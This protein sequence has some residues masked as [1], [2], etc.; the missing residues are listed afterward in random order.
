MKKILALSELEYNFDLQNDIRAEFPS[1]FIYLSGKII[2]ALKLNNDTRP[3]TLD[4]WFELCHPENHNVIQKIEYAISNSNTH[5]NF[6][7]ITRKL[8]CGDGVYRPFRLEAFLKRNSNGAV[9]ELLGKETPL[10]TAWLEN[11][12]NEGDLIRLDNN[13]IYEAVNVQGIMTLRDLDLIQDAEQENLRLRREIQRRI[14]NA[15]ALF[16]DDTAS[17]NNNHDEIKERL[18]KII[19]SALNSL[20]S[21]NKLRALKKILPEKNI[22]VGVIGLAGSGKSSFIN[23]LL[24][25]KLL[26]ESNSSKINVPV[27]CSNGDTRHAVIYYQNGMTAKISGDKLNS[28]KNL[29][30]NEFN[31]GN[32]HGIERIEF[33]I[34]GA[35]IPDGVKFVDTPSLNSAGEN[36]VM[37]NLIPELDFIIYITPSRAALRKY[38]REFINTLGERII[39]ILSEIDTE[40]DDTEAG[41]IITTSQN[42]IANAIA[43]IKNIYDKPVI[44]VSAKTALEKFYDR[45]SNEWLNANFDSVIK[46]FAQFKDNAFKNALYLRA[47]RLMDT[48]SIAVKNRMSA[49]I[50]WRVRENLDAVKN[51][52]AEFENDIPNISEYDSV[53]VENLD[54]GDDNN[55]N[56]IASLFTSMREREFK[57]KF[58]ELSAF[59]F[60]KRIILLAPDQSDSLKLFS[61]LAHDI[62]LTQ[63]FSNDGF[64]YSGDDEIL[65]R[66]FSAKRI[67][68][69]HDDILIAPSDEFL[70]DKNL[71]YN[72]IFSERVP[73]ISLD[74]ARIDTGFF[75]LENAKYFDALKNFQW[76]LAFGS[77]AFFDIKPDDLNQHVPERLNDFL[78]KHLLKMP[79][80]FI[81]E[82]YQIKHAAF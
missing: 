81:Y 75:E 48:L 45:K 78:K 22:I 13:K 56:L 1:R 7:T 10:L 8:Y 49:S 79:E 23:A 33:V 26:P 44:P 66:D 24:G 9:I 53:F 41:R 5:E 61:R 12:A 21:N 15:N 3:K 69:L 14:F 59:K 60:N 62:K 42:K 76:V 16:K 32:K 6:F 74:L 58:F 30:S 34:P 43:K 35:I 36:I 47:E 68:N 28:I 17:E 82:N 55:K 20:N 80:L 64:L 52:I 65:G 18:S 39:F 4:Q 67:S 77:G 57:S 11:F 70:S 46:L 63:T 31:S 38:E 73:V 2:R 71:N 29:S 50:K 19:N 27:F 40:R 72:E 25:E 51:L 54:D 37:R